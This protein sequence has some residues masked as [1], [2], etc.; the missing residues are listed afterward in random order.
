ML[1]QGDLGGGVH[2]E[3]GCGAAAVVPSQNRLA[4]FNR[5]P[6][7]HAVVDRV[8]FGVC[9]TQEIRV[10]PLGVRK[11]VGRKRFDAIQK[12][13]CHRRRCRPE[14]LK[15]PLLDNAVRSAHLLI[16]LVLSNVSPKQACG[17]LV[18]RR[19]AQNR[20]LKQRFL[21]HRR[22]LEEV[23]EEKDNITAKWLTRIS[24]RPQPKIDLSQQLWSDKRNFV[25]DNDPD[26]RELCP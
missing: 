17:L 5:K 16:E 6:S 25:D 20:A 23:A 18:L 21:T 9:R 1:S 7:K 14:V 4:I 3:G 19:S 22:N 13:P 24:A 2:I 15:Q 11:V 10:A 26:R 12:F 8:S